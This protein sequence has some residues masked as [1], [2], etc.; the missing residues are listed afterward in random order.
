MMAAG[1]PGLPA[2]ESGSSLPQ[3]LQP[4]PTQVTVTVPAQLEVDH[5]RNTATKHG[6]WPEAVPLV[7]PK[8]GSAILEP[9]SIRT[10]SASSHQG[11]RLRAVGA[12]VTHS[13]IP[14]ITCAFMSANSSNSANAPPPCNS[15]CGCDSDWELPV[16]ASP[17]ASLNADGS[18]GNMGSFFADTSSAACGETT[19]LSPCTGVLNGFS[20]SG[21]VTS[22]EP[23][24]RN[25]FI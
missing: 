11:A 3:R 7:G 6:P 4:V 24:E 25:T 21:Y 19:T 10:P 13:T 5:P 22:T 23:L 1:S 14:T 18:K 15:A 2:S 8:P 9:T 12:F 20:S 16:E 17:A